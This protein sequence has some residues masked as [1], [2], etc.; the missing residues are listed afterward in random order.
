MKTKKIILSLFIFLNINLLYGQGIVKKQ[1]FARNLE[2]YSGI[3]EYNSGNNVFRIILKN[4]SKDTNISYGPCL[5]GDY[6]YS[7]NNV[8]YDSCSISNIPTIY[9]DLTSETIIIFA[10]NGKYV[11]A[12]YANPNELNM[13][14]FDKQ[15]KKR[16][17]SGKIQLI[18]PTQIRWLLED[19]EGE[20][21][22]E[23][24]EEPGFSVPT[25]IIMTKIGI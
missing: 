2:A 20:C 11:S 4:G 17:Y 25:N 21:D 19:D 18:S 1:T 3:W 10:T 5:I 9:N 6:F 13:F 14:F 23:N 7:K 24:W 8:I 16:V 15:R 12:N 22:I